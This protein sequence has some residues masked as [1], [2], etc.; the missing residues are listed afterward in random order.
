MS[1]FSFFKRKDKEIPKVDNKISK[2]SNDT[3]DL[4]KKITINLALE[5]IEEE[6]KDII[7][8]NLNKLR[9]ICEETKQSFEVIN[10]IA[11]KI[12]LEKTTKTVEE[13]VEKLIPLINNTRS[14]VVKSLRRESANVLEIPE[15]YEDLIKFKETVDS[16]IKRFGEV[17]RSHSAVINNFL[18]KHANN[19]RSELKKITE[20]Y[21]EI[22]KY[23]KKIV[24]EKKI[25]DECKINLLEISNKRNEIDSNINAINSISQSIK[26]KEDD[27][28]LKKKEIKQ[29]QESHSYNKG[30]KYLNE[31]DQLE[32]RKEE[33]IQNILDIANQLSKAA[34]KYSYG[35]SKETKE[36]IN[37]I[38]K[39][40][41][42]ITENK[43]ILPYIEFLNNL[44]KATST[45]K[46]VLKDASKVI[47]HC[48]KLIEILPKFKD[49]STEIISKIHTLKEQNRDSPLETI[50]KIEKDIEE[51][52]KSI[53]AENLR[54][55]EIKSQ[56][57]QEEERL[58]SIVN[59]SEEQLFNIFKE[60]Y[61]IALE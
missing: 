11:D 30:L 39:D 9:K 5:K 26:K 59:K 43:D 7:K 3:Y 19:L 17:T 2:R 8:N 29:L 22:D 16:S 38:I 49:E 12:E 20:K 18:K 50:I 51:N 56:K 41:I 25:I 4:D 28:R 36:I 32:K 10:S 1:P 27:N 57:F 21:K 47:Q 40:P 15:T 48:D 34:H 24:D 6:E 33:L 54:M 31:I 52:K 37:N 46:I 35:S 13:E 14:I 53:E 44:K 23:Y 61:E 58:K 60:R 42:K 45:N 55:D